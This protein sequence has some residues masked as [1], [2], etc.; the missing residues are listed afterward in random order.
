MPTRAR[1]RWR[2]PGRARARVRVP[3]PVRFFLNQVS[4]VWD[5]ADRTRSAIRIWTR[6]SPTANRKPSRTVGRFL[7]KMNHCIR[8]NR[9]NRSVGFGQFY[10]SRS[11]IN[12]APFLSN[13]THKN[14]KKYRKGKR[15][16]SSAFRSENS[17]T[18]IPKRLP[19][20]SENSFWNKTQKIQQIL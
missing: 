14:R 16:P 2:R 7:S 5:T 15:I 4:R 20:D 12:S 19:T 10:P 6:I 17:A 3:Y 8:P 11:A 1:H 13:N 18:R 9:C